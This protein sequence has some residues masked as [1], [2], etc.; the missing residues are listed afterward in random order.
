MA[1]RISQSKLVMHDSYNDYAILYRTNAQSRTIEEALRNRNIPYRIYG[2]LAFYQRK[3]VKDA[4]AYFR[5]A[6]NP[7]DDE[8]LRRIIN[9]PARGIGDTTLKKLV[10]AALENN[11]SIL[12]VIKNLEEYKV[13]VNK[14]MAGKLIRFADMIDD[15]NK[16]ST[17]NNA[18]ETA[19]YIYNK[20]GIL[21]I[22][23]HDTTPEVITRQE[24]LTELLAGIKEYVDSKELSGET[25]TD[26]V[27]F[28]RECS[29]PLTRMKNL[30]M[31][32]LR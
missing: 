14:G 18:L 21:S 10:S 1:S 19:Q 6:I 13:A 31:K 16:Y 2:G 27:S 23:E 29:F 26:L 11:V 22:L 12:Q 30:R 20:T 9:Y 28:L 32:S 17:T 5:L 8:A 25:D 3:E 7:D 15:F 4:I 24:N